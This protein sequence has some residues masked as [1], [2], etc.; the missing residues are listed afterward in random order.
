MI[1]KLH[2]IQLLQ[3]DGVAQM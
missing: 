2:G 3:S 1:F